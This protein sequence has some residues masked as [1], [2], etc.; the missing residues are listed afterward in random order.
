MVIT[1]QLTRDAISRKLIH[2]DFLKID[3]NKEITTH[4]PIK[5]AGTPVGV[6]QGGILVHNLNSIEMKSLPKDMLDVYD[7][8]ISTLELEKSIKVSDLN[9]PS[10]V[11]LITQEERTICH[12][13]LPKIVQEVEEETEGEEGEEGAEGDEKDGESGEK[14]EG[15]STEES[16]DGEA[17]NSGDTDKKGES[18]A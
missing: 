16:K 6:V 8:D 1:H 12:I 14:K 11:T 18:N 15:S 9:I 2:L 13:E 7:L 17:K 10:E 4:V 3:M 5:Y